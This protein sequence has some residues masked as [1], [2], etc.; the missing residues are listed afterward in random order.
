LSV[1]IA[2]SQNYDIWLFGFILRLFLCFCVVKVG[3]W[4]VHFG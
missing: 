3:G 2:M 4:E 1:N